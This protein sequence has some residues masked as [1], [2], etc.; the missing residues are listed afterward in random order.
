MSDLIYVRVGNQWNYI[1][2]LVDLFNRKITGYS[3]CKNRDAI[4]VS[5]AFARVNANLKNIQ[6]FHT[7]K[8]NEF[9]NKLLDETLKI[10]DIKRS[11]SMKGCR[12]D[13]AVVVATFK[14]I[15]TDNPDTH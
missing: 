5:K 7:D 8:S 6:I 12:Y 9:K 10:F 13:N 14:T 1:C 15:K 3:A 11:L 2:V 4:L